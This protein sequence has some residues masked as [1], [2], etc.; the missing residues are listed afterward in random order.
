M[1]LYL[2]RELEEQIIH[3]ISSDATQ[4]LT[5]RIETNKSRNDIKVYWPFWGSLQ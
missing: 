4:K 3:Y 1:K 2:A 5:G